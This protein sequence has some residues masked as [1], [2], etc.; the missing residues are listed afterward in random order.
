M[1]IS[2]EIVI[3]FL[4][5]ATFSGCDKNPTESEPELLSN[6][7]ITFINQN[8]NLTL[9]EFTSM[10]FWK[11]SPDGTIESKQYNFNNNIAVIDSISPGNYSARCSCTLHDKRS[12]YLLHLS[13][14]NDFTVESNQNTETEFIV[15]EEI[16][17]LVIAFK[18]LVPLINA[19]VTTEPETVTV[20]TDENG[21][22]NLGILPVT[23]YIFTVKVNN[24]TIKSYHATIEII[25]G[26]Y[27]RISI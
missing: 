10:Y 11:E 15:P 21:E 6:V 2:K 5:L 3:L 16:E 24:I 26:Q 22:A 7:L 9:E 19:E 23:Y 20:F 25:N 18:N 27:G 13:F 12:K 4:F 8:D 17:L 1:N 14:R